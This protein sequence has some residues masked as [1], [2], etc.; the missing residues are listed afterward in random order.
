MPITPS[1]FCKPFF[2]Q[3]TAWGLM[4]HF[5]EYSV[6]HNVTPFENPGYAPDLITLVTWSNTKQGFF[7]HHILWF[8]QDV[9]PYHFN[10][11]NLTKI[12]SCVGLKYY[13][14]P[15]VYCCGISSELGICLV[16]VD[17]NVQ[18]FLN[19]NL[20]QLQKPS[21]VPCPHGFDLVYEVLLS[22]ENF[23]KFIVISFYNSSWFFINE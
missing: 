10:P 16:L 23:L 15:S 20:I 22:R 17:W 1:P 9:W 21:D 3:N 14:L 13:W 11:F 5:D 2:K 19:P 6:W 7:N 18:T 4:W 8:L 12:L